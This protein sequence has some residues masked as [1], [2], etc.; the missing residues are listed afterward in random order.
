MNLLSIDQTFY[1]NKPLKLFR[2]QFLPEDT[3]LNGSKSNKKESKQGQ[4]HFC[5]KMFKIQQNF[6]GVDGCGWVWM[7]KIE[8]D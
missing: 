1:L 8:Q 2:Q 7:G 4:P 5:K 3:K 6:E